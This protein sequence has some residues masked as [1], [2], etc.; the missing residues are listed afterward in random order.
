MQVNQTILDK[1]AA[2]IQKVLAQIHTHT[3]ILHTLFGKT[4]K[5]K[6]KKTVVVGF[7]SCGK[8]PDR[9]LKRKQMFHPLHYFFFLLISRVEHSFFG[10]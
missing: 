7:I 10:D 8:K 9:D 2:F 5:G 1:F 6:L 4:A 3:Q